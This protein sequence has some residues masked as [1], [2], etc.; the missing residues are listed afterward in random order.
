M[1]TNSKNHPEDQEVDFAVVSKKIDG[2]K[3]SVKGGIFNS[4]QFVLRNKIV[5]G[6]LL[7][8]GVGIGLYLDKVNKTYENQLVVKPNFGSADYLYAKVSLLESKIKERDTMFLNA[9]GIKDPSKMSKIEITPVI[10]IYQFINN[11]SDRNFELLKLMAEDSDMKKTLEERPTSKNY[12]YHLITF[13]TKSKTNKDK[14]IQPLL[15]FLNNSA[16]YSKIQKEELNNIRIRMKANDV[17]LTQIDNFL[18]G[19]GNGGASGQKLV[20]YNENSPLNDIIETKERLVR[21]Q[22]NQRINLVTADKIIKEV[23]QVINI[24]NKE[25]T[26][27]KLKL[28]LPLLFI[29]IFVMVRLFVSFY[30]EQSLKRQA[31]IS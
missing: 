6:L 17:I 21:E 23:S 20:Y 24:E 8:L 1:S 26:N 28:I 7:V 16:F 2:F 27:G 5:L 22:G 14:T 19:I 29:L 4:I 15:D 30:K 13:N 12:T 31:N 10:D 25:A 3:Q 18:N 9:V 11:N